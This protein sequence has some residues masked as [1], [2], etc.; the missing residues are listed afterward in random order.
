MRLLWN[1]EN[2]T[3]PQ[4]K[5]GGIYHSVFGIENFALKGGVLNPKKTSGEVFYKKKRPRSDLNR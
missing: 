4:P 3:N 5:G 2:R 1:N